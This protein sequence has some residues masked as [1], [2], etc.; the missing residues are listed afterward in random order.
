MH[1]ILYGKHH[2]EYKGHIY[3]V[4]QPSLELKYR[5]QLLYD[6]MVSS[7]RFEQWISEKQAKLLLIQ[8]GILSPV[9]ENDLKILNDSLENRKLELYQNF[10][11]TKKCNQVRGFIRQIENSIADLSNTVHSLQHFTLKGYANLCMQ[12]FILMNSICDVEDNLVCGMDDSY[13]NYSLLT[14]VLIHSYITEGSYRAV[15]R[16]NQW[17]TYWRGTNKNPF[18]NTEYL[19]VEQQRLAYYTQLY[20]NIYQ[21]QDCPPSEVIE[22]D[23]MLDGWMIHEHRKDEEGKKQNRAEQLAQKHGNAQEI[24]VMAN[25]QEDRKVIDDLNDTRGKVIKKQRHAKI[26][27]TTGNLQELDLPDRRADLNM[28]KQQ[29]MSQTVKNMKGK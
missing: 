13:L 25:N 15:G 11:D 2:I 19:T 20:D 9:Y 10:T 4:K 1:R 5:A 28:Q 26:A 18:G 17:R 21:N 22:D 6:K 24:F 8:V 16:D 29:M 3:I 14:S 7:N 23:D 12:E 27:S